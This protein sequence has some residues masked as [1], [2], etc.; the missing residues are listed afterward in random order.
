MRKLLF[1]L[2]LL[3]FA[4]IAQTK[5][6]SLETPP[7]G[8]I[9][10]KVTERTDRSDSTYY[11]TENTIRFSTV[12]EAKDYVYRFFRE[13]LQSDSLQLAFV[14]KQRAER[15]AAYQGL[16]Y[17]LARKEKETKPVTPKTKPPTKKK[18]S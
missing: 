6:Y 17:E 9:F 5:T 13:Q 11:Q 2:M 16:T 7:G 4:A 10:L 8:A 12:K 14:A 15:A 1:V 3:P 18:G